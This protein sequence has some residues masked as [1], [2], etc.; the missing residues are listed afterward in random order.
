MLKRSGHEL[1]GNFSGYIWLDTD[2][3]LKKRRN[4]RYRSM[5]VFRSMNG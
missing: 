4:Y 5:I 1:Q 3:V 2:I